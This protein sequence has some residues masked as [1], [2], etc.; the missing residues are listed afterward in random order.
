MTRPLRYD[1]SFTSIINEK[2][3]EN[4]LLLFNIK[5]QSTAFQQ[6]LNLQR[7][8]IIVSL[9]DLFVGLV[10][11]LLFFLSIDQSYD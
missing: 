4:F 9:F 2:V 8:L 3:H 11:S 7:S 10:I 5:V 6:K 1:D